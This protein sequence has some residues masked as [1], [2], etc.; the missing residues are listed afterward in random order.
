MHARTPLGEGKRM[1][2][3]KF[4]GHAAQFENCDAKCVFGIDSEMRHAGKRV[5]PAKILQPG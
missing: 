4:L 5:G 3:P 1:I 2:L